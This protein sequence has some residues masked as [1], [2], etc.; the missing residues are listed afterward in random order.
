MSVESSVA[1]V[2]KTADVLGSECWAGCSCK[3]VCVAVVG[4]D[5][6]GTGGVGMIGGVVSEVCAELVGNSFD[7]VSVNIA[8]NSDIG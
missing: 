8:I 7:M 3:G 5:A 1:S 2:V 6:G 4:M